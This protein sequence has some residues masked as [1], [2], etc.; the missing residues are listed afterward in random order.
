MVRSAAYNAHTKNYFMLRSYLEKLEKKGG[1]VLV[2]K[3][4]TYSI[5][6]TLYVP[7]NTRIVLNDGVVIEKGSHT[8]TARLVP[9]LSLFQTIGPSRSKNSAVVGGYDGEQNITFQGR[10]NATIDLCYLKGGIGIVFGHN[11]AVTVQ[12][13]TFKRMYA[14]HFIELDATD[15][16]QISGNS[17]VQA[18][19]YLAST[20]EAINLDA[21]DPTT[22]GFNNK[23]SKMD[24]TPNANVVID[25]N[26]FSNLERAVGTHKYSYGKSHTNIVVSNNTI[27][28]I[29]TDAIWMLN[30][31]NSRVENN[32]ISR[33]GTLN[34]GADERAVRVLGSVNPS[35]T[36][37]KVTS[38][39]RLAQC[40]PWRNRGLGSQYETI[41]CGWDTRAVFDRGLSTNT[42]SGVGEDFV[43]INKSYNVY[44]A[45]TD[46]VRFQ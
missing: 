39:D 33:V 26:T 41:Y 20:K 46:R 17:F 13:I 38:V 27:D 3:K 34:E 31:V 29:R 30:W 32:M 45:D 35:I 43:R 28:T 36:N 40:S 25:N 10:G 9:S 12:G 6:N 11:R 1:G 21:P 4:G 37:N 24:C 44:D 15:G 19:S 22:G 16:A 42:A 14:G 2:L 5:T 23:W 18:K 7:S 8:S